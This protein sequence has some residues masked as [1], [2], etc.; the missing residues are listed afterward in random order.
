MV[1]TNM[2]STDVASVF[3]NNGYFFA[4]SYIAQEMKKK[5]YVVLGYL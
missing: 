1:F 5:N 2:K 3:P 4:K